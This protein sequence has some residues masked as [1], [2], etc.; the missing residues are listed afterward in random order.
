MDGQASTGW[1]ST[2]PR[3]LAAVAGLLTALTTLITG[4]CVALNKSAPVDPPGLS[5]AGVSLAGVGGP[6]ASGVALSLLELPK[7]E[8]WALVGHYVDGRL[9]GARIK[10]RLAMPVPV[11]TCEALEDFAVYNDDPSDNTDGGKIRLG[12]VHKG[13]M[14]EVL[15]QWRR[16]TKNAAVHVMIRAVLHA[17]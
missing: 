9:S 15:R 5:S 6:A 14:V 2:L 3:T 11:E 16:D 12:F 13:E 10:T 7:S 4:V 8:G 1:F 17:Q